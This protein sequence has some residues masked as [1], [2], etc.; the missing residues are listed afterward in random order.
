VEPQGR[1][2]L[3]ATKWPWSEWQPNSSSGDKLGTEETQQIR[4]QVLSNTV[5]VGD[6]NTTF[7]SIDRSS[8]QKINKEILDLKYTIDQMDLHD[9]YRT[10]HP[11]STQYSQQPMEPSPK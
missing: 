2:L 8:K 6:F 1:V 3:T 7:S 5:V 9:G 10:F 11:T 4:K